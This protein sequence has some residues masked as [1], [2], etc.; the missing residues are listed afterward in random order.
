MAR[1]DFAPGQ[2]GENFTTVGL[3]ED[4]VCVGDKLRVGG[5]LIQVTQPRVP[6]YK[7]ANKLGIRGFDK[8]LLASQPLGLLRAGARRGRSRGGG[9][10]LSASAAT[11]SA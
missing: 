7:L 1:D 11:R 2:F 9:S 6:C 4:E 10:A 5:A 8:T 3:L